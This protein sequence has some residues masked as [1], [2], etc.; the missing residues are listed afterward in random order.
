VNDALVTV[1]IPTY[2]RPAY[3]KRI[4]GY[5]SNFRIPCKIILADGSPEEITGITKQTIASFPAMQ[6]L[7]LDGYTPD[8]PPQKRV[9]DALNRVDTRYSVFCA[10]DD[11]ITPGGLLGAL[12][13]LEANPGYAIVHGKY[14]GFRFVENENGEKTFHWTDAHT[15]RSITVDDP[16]QRLSSHLMEYDVSTFYAVHRTTLLKMIWEETLPLVGDFVFSELLP[17]MLVL[18]YGKMKCLDIW[19]CARDGSSVRQSHVPSLRE[20]MNKGNYLEKYSIFRKCL[21]THLS[22]QS[23]LDIEASGEI[24]DKAMEG[25]LGKYYSRQNASTRVGYFL[26]KLKLPASVRGWIR[27]IY[28][29]LVKVKT[30]KK[31]P[32]S[33]IYIPEYDSEL[34]QIKLHVLADAG[35]VSAK[36]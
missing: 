19:Y 25:Y 29:A 4:L 28:S 3:V 32:G 23:H 35:Q 20:Y 16:S 36:V 1:I 24:V 5:F 10:D 12:D 6:I 2:K 7:H 30:G 15:S 27:Q 18:I 8:T 26:D 34:E 17:S 31:S 21:A 22:G 9:M 14:I 33:A 13:F 11:F